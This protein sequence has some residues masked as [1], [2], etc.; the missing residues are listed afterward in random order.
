[1][2]EPT[3]NDPLIAANQLK[4][5]RSVSIAS[6]FSSFVDSSSDG[7]AFRNMGFT[8][9]LI[10]SLGVGYLFPFSAMTQPV[11]YWKMLFPDVDMDFAISAV[12]MYTN[13]I[14]LYAVVFILPDMGYT[15]RIVGG[16]LGQA[17]VLIFVPSSY[18]LY[19]SESV[20]YWIV[21]GATATI[22]IITAL[23]DSACLSLAARF[24][25]KCQESLQIGIGF[26]TLIGSV[27]RVLTK[28]VFPPTM[29]VISSVLYFYSGA[30]TLLACI[31]GYYT[32][33]G[34]PLAKERLAEAR[35][36]GDDEDMLLPE[37]QE[38]QLTSEER[39]AV[40]RKVAPNAALVLVFFTITLSLWPGLISTIPCYSNPRWN[41][42]WWP[43]ILLLIFSSM[44]TLGR[45]CVQHRMGLTSNNIWVPIA[46]RA[47]LIPCFIM[48]VKGIVFTHDAWS[49]LFTVLLGFTNGYI[50]TLSLLFI[51]EACEPNEA[52]YAG[53]L[54]S[55]FLNSG[56]VMGSTVGLVLNHFVDA[57]SR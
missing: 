37:E 9:F 11:D 29:T 54:V 23:L 7:I 51:I 43:V 50:G 15:P 16:F 52:G 18:Y 31:I 25:T 1:M 49:V 32:L 41:G 40:L 38:S 35:S 14:A 28:L 21:L 24:P 47:L 46:L 42:D 26:S 48:V 6:A 8:N 12:F 2:A 10:M 27:Y 3:E 56:L 39:S 33:L 19:L 4:R 20:N 53:S 57:M 44:D 36:G 45:F 5:L 30:A 55:F 17:L 34:Q 22:A 13:L